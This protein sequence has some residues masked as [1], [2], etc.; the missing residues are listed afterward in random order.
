MYE[1]KG[2][3]EEV[4]L[5]ETSQESCGNLTSSLP[6]F[7]SYNLTHTTFI[8]LCYN[9]ID[10]TNKSEDEKGHL[11]PRYKVVG[12]FY[13]CSN[14]TLSKGH[15]SEGHKWSSPY[16]EKWII[17]IEYLLPHVRC[18]INEEPECCRG[19]VVSVS[20]LTEDGNV[21]CVLWCSYRRVSTIL[22]Y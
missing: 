2:G 13:F 7:L 3:R 9:N 20:N 12:T 19:R 18:N 22:M 4:K 16:T 15:D 11:Q 6:L 5:E 21:G 8:P 10:I 14:E 1:T 17:I